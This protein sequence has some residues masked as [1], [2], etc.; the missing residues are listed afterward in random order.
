VN[1]GS[2]KEVILKKLEEVRVSSGNDVYQLYAVLVHRGGL[3]GGHYIA[4]ILDFETYRWYRCDDSYVR[5]VSNKYF[6][7]K[8]K[9]NRVLCA[10]NNNNQF[11]IL[12]LKGRL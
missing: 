5:K 6:F 3:T 2:S 4:Y 1:F 12:M 9:L 8:I 10:G 11:G 7:L